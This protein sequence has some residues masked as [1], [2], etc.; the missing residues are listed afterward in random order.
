MLSFVF[1]IHSLG[2]VLVWKMSWSWLVGSSLQHRQFSRRLECSI[3]PL[4]HGQPPQFFVTRNPAGNDLSVTRNTQSSR[5]VIERGRE[6][7]TG[8][9][10]GIYSQTVGKIQ[11]LQ[12]CLWQS[13]EIR[14]P[15]VFTFVTSFLHINLNKR[16]FL[17]VD[18]KP[19]EFESWG[20]S[21]SRW[22]G[23]SKCSDCTML[24]CERVWVSWLNLFAHVYGNI[25]HWGRNFQVKSVD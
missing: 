15:V 20:W 12:R 4:N 7:V 9:F 1:D 14:R 25:C 11:C 23:A 10:V 8:D 6:R 24:V 16:I 21:S 5:R 17:K 18:S 13:S 3:G 19:T 2:L 22:S